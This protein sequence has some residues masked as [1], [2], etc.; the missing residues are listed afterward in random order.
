M[1]ITMP[2]GFVDLIGRV[3]RY[4]GYTY[5]LPETQRD[6]FDDLVYWSVLSGITN[7][8]QNEY[9]YRL[10][11]EFTTFGKVRD[12]WSMTAK[13]NLAPEQNRLTK[14]LRTKSRA[15]VVTRLKLDAVK[16]VLERRVIL[17]NTLLEAQEVIPRIWKQ[18]GRL[19]PWRNNKRVIDL[20][21]EIAHPNGKYKISDVGYVKATKWLQSCGVGQ[22][23]VA[24]MAQTAKFLAEFCNCSEFRRSDTEYK[25]LGG[26][27][28]VEMPQVLVDWG[29]M[30][31]RCQELAGKTSKSWAN[32]EIVG[33]TIHVVMYVRGLMWFVADNHVASRRV[34]CASL[35]GFLKRRRLS[36]GKFMEG[37]YDIERVPE[38]VTELESYLS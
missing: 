16:K 12:T 31:L 36:F 35:L 13:R 15:R 21:A 2:P 28:E 3:R 6:F 25:H 27:E 26:L 19:E 24:P 23:L 32:P 7:S 34:T 14:E 9:L 37:I 20:V 38:I 17:N 11:E 8:A 18:E 29:P 1:P 33:D 5:T 10:L 30:N 4:W 22:E